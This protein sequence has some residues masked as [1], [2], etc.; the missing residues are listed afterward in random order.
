MGRIDVSVI[1][2]IVNQQLKTKAVQ[3][4]ITALKKDVI[5]SGKGLNSTAQS[6][7]EEASRLLFET[8]C[9]H[10]PSPILESMRKNGGLSNTEISQ[11]TIKDECYKIDIKIPPE[12]LR[13]DSLYK[14]KYP[15]GVDNIIALFDNGYKARKP[16]Y[17]FWNTA[18]KTVS[19]VTERPALHFMQEAIDEFNAK[20]GSLYGCKAVLGKQY[21]K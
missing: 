13:R 11:P 7:M 16:V 8:I 14:D 17:G 9:A 19:S 21:N 10:L 3:N 18:G 6:R 1:N 5:K 12:S 20:Y 15:E 4:K 2:A